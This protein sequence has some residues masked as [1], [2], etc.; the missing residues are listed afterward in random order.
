MTCSFAQW[1]W[2]IL[3]SRQKTKHTMLNLLYK[4]KKRPSVCFSIYEI[5]CHILT[6]R[7]WHVIYEAM[8]VCEMTNLFPALSNFWPP[9]QKKNLSLK[10]DLNDYFM[11]KKSWQLVFFWSTK[12]YIYTN[13]WSFSV[14]KK[15][16]LQLPFEDESPVGANATS[17]CLG[18]P[19]TVL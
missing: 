8:P 19:S 18:K 1:N 14:Q 7:V 6:S 12:Q 2:V 11:I 16:K 3:S 5:S 17:S 15:T 4:L 13:C 9:P 10:N